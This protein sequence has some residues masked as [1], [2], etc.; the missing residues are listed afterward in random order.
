MAMDSSVRRKF[1]RVVYTDK[2]NVIVGDQLYPGCTI[3]NLSLSGMFLT[4]DFKD[5]LPKTI[6]I[7]FVRGKK[8]NT[9][10]LEAQG[11]VAW[12]NDDGVGIRFHSMSFDCY[13]ALV[14]ELVLNAEEP[15]IVLKEIPEQ[16][17]FE[18]SDD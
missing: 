8:N 7:S 18:I 14:E 6:R 5:K 9:I 16:S 4:G 2:A 10:F 3:K 13:L 11:D 15:D 1:H 17:P 12:A